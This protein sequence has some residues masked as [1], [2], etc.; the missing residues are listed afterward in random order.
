MVFLIGRLIPQIYLLFPTS[1]IFFVRSNSNRTGLPFNTSRLLPMAGE[2]KSL[3]LDENAVFY[4]QFYFQALPVLMSTNAG[5]L[6]MSFHPLWA[7][8]GAEAVLA[9]QGSM[10]ACEQP[11]QVGQMVAKEFTSLSIVA[12]WLATSLLVIILQIKSVINI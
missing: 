6:F 12:C 10:A 2:A 9:A 7:A 3:P 8:E 4:Q 1:F 5:F 11:G